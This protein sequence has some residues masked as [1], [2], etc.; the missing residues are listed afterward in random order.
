MR[1]RSSDTLC[2]AVTV[3]GDRGGGDRADNQAAEMGDRCRSA[4]VGRVCARALSA[5]A[6]VVLVS[7]LVGLGERRAEEQLT[8]SARDI[9]QM[10]EVSGTA[11]LDGGA[12]LWHWSMH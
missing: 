3:G 10:C 7:W 8:A 11:A 5:R 4:G 12:V 9:A 2:D 1:H 6:C